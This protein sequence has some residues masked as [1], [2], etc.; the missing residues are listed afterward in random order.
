MFELVPF[1]ILL[2]ELFEFVNPIN[3]D[4]F[5]NKIDAFLDAKSDQLI[6]DWALAT[7]EDLELTLPSVV[8]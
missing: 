1:N 2:E 7:T 4:A 3:T 5:S 8:S 6:K